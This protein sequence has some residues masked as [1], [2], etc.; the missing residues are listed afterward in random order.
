MML[1]SAI[2][3]VLSLP[4]LSAYAGEN[5]L[6]RHSDSCLKYPPSDARAECMKKEREVSATFAK[7]R[8]REEAAPRRSEHDP[9]RKNELCFKREATGEIVCPN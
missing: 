1:K 9:S 3:F 7:E 4:V 6:F 2:A 8:K 5:A